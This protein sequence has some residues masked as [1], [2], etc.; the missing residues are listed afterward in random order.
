M[1]DVQ[2]K[3]LKYYNAL[4][5]CIKLAFKKGEESGIRLPYEKSME[6]LLE[7][8]NDPPQNFNA[9]AK[10]HHCL[11]ILAATYANLSMYQEALEL[12]NE[13]KKLKEKQTMGEFAL[14]VLKWQV[15]CNDEESP[16]FLE[17]TKKCEQLIVGFVDFATFGSYEVKVGS[18][19]KKGYFTY[20]GFLRRVADQG[21]QPRVTEY[22]N[23]TAT[24]KYFTKA[25]KG[26][27]KNRYNDWG[28]E[29]SF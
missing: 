7:I 21:N 10:R 16:E 3:P 28:N 8:R 29:S 9:W 6:F 4:F 23:G 27:Q 5:E 14:H 15:Y 2:D 1:A 25:G 18:E 11:E 19:M 24:K 17:A 20:K 26:I 12:F 13:R 22:I